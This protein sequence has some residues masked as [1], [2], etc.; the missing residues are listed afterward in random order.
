MRF[1]AANNLWLSLLALPI[2]AL[3]VLR[4]WRREVVVPSLWLWQAAAED[5]RANRPW[6]RLRRHWLL[7]LQLLVLATLVLAT[8]RP[9]LP[10]LPVPQ[11]QVLVLLD[12]SAS[13]QARRV[14]GGT[15][16][17]AALA[18]LRE[19]AASLDVAS[20]VTVIAVTAEPHVVLRDGD[21]AALRRLLP[22]L[23]P[24][25]GPANWPSAASLAAGLVTA[26]VPA[27]L[28][29]TDGAFAGP[30]P[31]LPGTVMLQVVVEEDDLSAMANVG[32]VAFSLRRSA[33]AYTAFVRVRNAGPAR[34]VTLLLLAEGDVLAR[35]VLELPHDGEVALVFSDLPAR[36]WYEARLEG[37]ADAL[38]LDDRAWIALPGAGFGRVLLVTA[39]NRFLEAALRA[40]PG[41]EVTQAAAL[42]AEVADYGVVV[43]DRESFG[44]AGVP[45]WLI[46]PPVDTPC[47]IP[48]GVFT[49][50]GTLRATSHPLLQ[51]LT[52]EEVHLARA[53]RYTLPADARVLLEVAE[54]PLLWTVERP[55]QRLLCQAF[56]LQDSDLP[57]RVT[58]PILTINALTW[59]LP[60]T[61][62][63]PLFPLPAGRSWL[64]A[65]PLDT[66]AATLVT[67]EGARVAWAGQTPPALPQ[68]AGLYFLEIETPQGV[69][70]QAVA[71]ALLDATESDL[72]PRL[73]GAAALPSMWDTAA[74]AGWRDLSRWLIVAALG[75]L[76]LEGG[77]WWKRGRGLRDDGGA[78]VLR[79]L[80][81]C[82][83]GLALTDVRLTQRTRELVTVFVVDRSASVEAARAESMA[84]LAEAWKARGP[85][86]RSAVVFFGGEA[87]VVQP[88][89][90]TLPS[91]DEVVSLRPNATDIEAAVRLGMSLIPE[92]AAGR[93][94]LLT[95]GLE[96]RG[97]A[98]AALLQARQRGVETLIAPIG[99]VRSPEVWV[100]ALRL[101][102]RVYPGDV[103]AATAVLG[104]THA[105][106]VRF[107]WTVGGQSAT[108]VGDV[109][110]GQKA[111][112]FS[113]N[114][115]APGLTPVRFCIEAQADGFIE[116]NCAG[117]W[118]RVEGAPR[119]LVVGVPEERAALAEAL[120]Q[121]GLEV[122]EQLPAAMPLSAQ[123]L[124]DYAA[125]ILVN[126]PAR[127]LPSQAPQ[128]IQTF[129]RDLG[130]GL[131]AIG[132]PTSYGVGGWSQTALEAALPVTMQVQDPQRFPPL[133]LVIVIDKSG[134]MAAPDTGPGLPGMGSSKIRLAAEAA[135]RV[136][137]ALRDD[138]V[139]AVVAYDDRPAD[140]LGPVS[141]AERFLLME[142]LL[143]LQAGGGGIY[144]RDSLNYAEKLLREDFPMAP[145]QQRH[146]LLV[147]DGSDA[148]QQVG[149]P[150]QLATLRAQGVTV[151][152][153]AVG[154]GSDVPF[155]QAT[156]V[157]GGGRFYLTERAADLPVIFT[158]D[159]AQARRSYIVEQ[160]FYPGRGTSWPPLADVEAWP[161]LLG[162]V[163]TTP[164][165]GAEIALRGAVPVDPVLAAWQYGL[166]RAVAWTSDASGRWAAPWLGWEEFARFWG[167][168][169][170]W[171]LPPPADDGMALQVETLG[172]QARLTLDV[173]DV[174]TGTYVEGLWLQVQAAQVG[175]AEMGVT[176]VFSQTAPGRYA[177]V[178]PLGS[179]TS[180]WLFRISGDR[181]LLT[182]WMAP[183]GA[184]YLPGEPASAIERLR[185]Q[186]QARLL[187]QAQEAFAPTLQGRQAGMP[188]RPWLILVVTLLWPLDIAVRRLALT[189]QE[190]R[191]FLWRLL[192][193]AGLRLIRRP[194]AGTKMPPAEKPVQPASQDAA[195]PLA[196]Q[197]KRRLR[198]PS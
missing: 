69:Q 170:R 115:P 168:V 137:E 7:L 134:S 164:K 173:R 30:L 72:R 186:G 182:G 176:A 14:A 94:V 34:Q 136:A 104:A 127:A 63:A 148:E 123:G 58:F 98:A 106:P 82:A 108:A 89:G 96:T 32:L 36:P 116:N 167:Q 196:T 142:P 83:L 144:V 187:T 35:R 149:V 198:P 162:Y 113:F 161:P 119:L 2:V 74:V 152:V 165:P 191:A 105:Q 18:A 160:A 156:A 103:V 121:T 92:G 17:D 46:A 10:A 157:Q 143:R 147:A 110:G 129:V 81:L 11:G 57:L 24:T 99:E 109:V 70:T 61:S 195:E 73:E 101:P 178:L 190:A 60:Q 188:L 126:T 155:L 111:F 194:A 8:A 76:L 51:Y 85:A 114:A 20:R 9:A 154:T 80:L 102:A 87:R 79:W 120:R 43:V 31:P 53:N 75:L 139:L 49:P 118:L 21:A 55:G 84:L 15:R 86:D 52:W 4:L 41:F 91:W 130:G 27:T 6:Q 93:L 39:G 29:L 56:A 71:L 100:E 12:A 3:Y 37:A 38:P 23:A 135:L 25:D 77:I 175:H 88:L 28:V 124:G 22:T 112:L 181:Q 33:E 1:L 132:G 153:I 140:T 95:D 131:I 133:A 90:S 47:G 40:V 97:D 117:G 138:D 179:A 185:I 192:R 16:F 128:A 125:L 146:I 26:T 54:G 189:W 158:E 45:A 163:A 145:G 48:T 159:T 177:A 44:A 107:A 50:T 169:V 172:E 66:L 78:V 122:V 141:G 42:P 166:G 184:E 59:L 151:S 64:P 5:R 193:P 174:E 180:P 62:Q 67:P 183:Y 150:E 197:L 68:R 19:L 65:L 13:M 171:V